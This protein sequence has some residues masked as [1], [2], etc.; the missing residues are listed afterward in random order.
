MQKHG[1]GELEVTGVKMVFNKTI[2]NRY[3]WLAMAALTL[4]FCHLSSYSIS[5]I[6]NWKITT[7]RILNTPQIFNKSVEERFQEEPGTILN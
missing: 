4:L 5:F 6:N 3:D 2:L 7:S 1:G